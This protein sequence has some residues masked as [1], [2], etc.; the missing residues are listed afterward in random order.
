MMLGNISV[1]QME[2]RLCITLSDED[3][4]FLEDRRQEPINATDLGPGKFH[5]FDIP[6]MILCDTKATAKTIVD[7]LKKYDPSKFREPI[8]ISYEKEE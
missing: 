6:F 7:I 1:L 8:R 4:A 2:H 5:I 3:R